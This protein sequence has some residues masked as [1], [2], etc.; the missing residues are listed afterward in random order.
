VISSALAVRFS[1]S[2]IVTLEAFFNHR[3]LL[4]IARIHEFGSV[5]PR[6]IS[7][8]YETGHK[9]MAAAE[10]VFE[11]QTFQIP[12]RSLLATCELFLKK[13]NMVRTGYQVRSQV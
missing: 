4:L 9:T 11:C 1:K 8:Y 13:P 7:E 10:L 12:R 5:K 2:S 3:S 6:G